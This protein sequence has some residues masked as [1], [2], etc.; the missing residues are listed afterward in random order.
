MQRP[1]H[2]PLAEIDDR[3]MQDMPRSV[4]FQ[5]RAAIAIK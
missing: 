3:P 2:R 5:P 4:D 1:G